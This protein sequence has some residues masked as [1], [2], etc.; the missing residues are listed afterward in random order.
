MSRRI[1]QTTSTR[2]VA[3]ADAQVSC[4]DADRQVDIGGTRFAEISLSLPQVE[5]RGR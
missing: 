3:L 2:A 1:G 4:H 5:H